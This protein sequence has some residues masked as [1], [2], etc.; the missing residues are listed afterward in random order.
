[1][2]AAYVQ[3]RHSD[4]RTLVRE[5]LV[6][7][8]LTFLETKPE[9]PRHLA[10]A[11]LE[12]SM[13]PDASSQ[14]P[15]W[16]CAMNIPRIGLALDSSEELAIYALRSGFQD[17]LRAP[18]RAADIEASVVRLLPL[19]READAESPSTIVGHSLAMRNLREQVIKV[20]RTRSNILIT[21]ETGTGK[22]LI[23][24]SIHEVSPRRARKF[25]AVNCGAIPE[26][27]IES[28]LFGYERGAFTGAHQTRLGRVRQSDG[29][30]LFLDEVSELDL[31]AQV[32]LLRVLETREVQSLGDERV[33]SLDLRVV[34]ASN[35]NLADRV[36]EKAFRQDLFYRLNVVQVEVPPLRARSEDIPSLIARFCDRYCREFGRR[37]ASYSAT[38][39]ELL[40]QYDWPGN[41][42]EL[43]NVVEASF[44]HSSAGAGS[45]LELPP[46]LLG[47]LQKKGPP[48][49][50]QRIVEALFV[51]HWNVSHAA[52]RLH[53][54]RMTLYRKILQYQLRRPPTDGSAI[55]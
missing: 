5:A 23:A 37:S 34:A 43:R 36:R 44:V 18:L 3:V 48:D 30:T 7:L 40:Q 12:L 26:G 55:A 39:L 14:A 22:E 47:A 1:M 11:I 9:D 53:C 28:E 35:Q 10:V 51:T 50:R 49:E 19:L 8:P 15:T 54:S 45:A 17:Y 25:V 38:D 52:L 20:A 21:G 31:R 2:L 13:G 41:V 29:G 46:V 6:G 42:R 16:L 24:Q 27:L 32:K 4:V 33:R